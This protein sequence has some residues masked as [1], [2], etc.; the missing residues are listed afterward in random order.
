MP[1]R[2]ESASLPVADLVGLAVGD[3]RGHRIGRAAVH[4]DLAVGVQRHEPPRRVD[5]RVDHRQ[6]EVVPFG[7]RAPV[8]DARPAQRVGADAD[9]L[10]ADGV[11]VDDVRQVVD[12]GVHVVVALRGLQRTGQRHPLHR[13][14]PVAQD[15][16]GPLGD[17]A[18]RVG[19]GRAAVGRVVLE[20]AVARRVVRR[21]D[22]DAVGQVAVAAAVERQDRVADGGRRRVAVGRVDHRHDVV[23][24]QHLQR[25]HPR[26]FGQRVGVAADEQRAGRALR[27]PV[28][29]DGLRGGQDVRL[30]ER[31]VQARPTMPGGPEGHLLVDVVRVGFDGVVGGDHLGH[32]DEIFGL[33]RLA[34]AGI[35]GHA[36]DSAP[37]QFVPYAG[38]EA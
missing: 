28:L 11:H 19:V 25:R 4:P 23:G 24:G 7:D 38:P 37:L 18:R 32:V 6:L 8:V 16:V 35:G 9:L 3:Q 20:S 26:R 13:L 2:S 36:L 21:G 15:L 10:G 27:L 22:D 33:R 31:G 30:V 34:G 14:E 1:C 17:H 29:R 5:Q 12:V